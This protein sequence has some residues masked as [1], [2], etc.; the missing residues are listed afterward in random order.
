MT[1]AAAAVP[2]PPG[3]LRWWATATAAGCQAVAGQLPCRDRIP[4]SPGATV[5]RVFAVRVVGCNVSGPS[6]VLSGPSGKPRLALT[7]DDGPSRYTRKV[8]ALLEA[9]H[10]HA[11]FFEVGN[12]IAQGRASLSRQVLA[13]G[14]EVGDHSW[15]HANLGGG[16]PAATDQMLRTNALIH[17]VT[18][19][20][21]CLFR[22]PYRATG[23]DLVRRTRAL[24]M[25]SVLWSVD[26]DDWKRPGAATLVSRLLAGADPGAIILMHDGGGIRDQT[27]EALRQALPQ[28]T[29]KFSVVTVSELLGYKQ[30]LRLVR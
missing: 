7:F 11:T 3:R 8:L 13:A 28:I 16:G 23:A 24:G 21:P 27:V 22:P 17:Q 10:A 6:E 2:L 5:G 30:R 20:E 4:D 26:T 9:N 19:F 29:R 1:F 15:N 12:Q 14:N 25:T 18:G